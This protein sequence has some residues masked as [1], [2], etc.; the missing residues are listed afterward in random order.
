[1]DA[2]RETPE[3]LHG[4]SADMAGTI[5]DDQMNAPGP[6]IRMK[7][8]P[9]G[10]SKM[11]AIIFLQALCPHMSVMKVQTGK[12]VEGAVTNVGKFLP[13]GLPWLH[14]LCR[15]G[16]LQD[17]QAGFLIHRQKQLALFPETLD[18]LVIPQ[19]SQAALDRFIIPNR[20]FPPAHVLRL[21]IRLIQQ[22]TDR[23][24]VN[25][26]YI[27]LLHGG[28]GQTTLRPM[29]QL[30]TQLAWR[31][32]GQSLNLFPL[33]PGKKPAAARS[34]WHRTT[35]LAAPAADNGGRPA[36]S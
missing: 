10:G 35:P 4:F 21:Q 17:L 18:S 33:L 15:K 26:F 25:A 27:F 28:F 34:G 1:M 14:G 3:K 22:G 23:G 32:Q 29:R 5:V 16:P 11:Q 31:S 24:G 30:P 36:K 9:Q 7:Q 12:Q 19:D 8:T 6:T 2:R 13:L 20:I